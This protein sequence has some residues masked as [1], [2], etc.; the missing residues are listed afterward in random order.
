M[1]QQPQPAAVQQRVEAMVNDYLRAHGGRA[2]V[3]IVQLPNQPLAALAADETFIPA[4]NQKLLTCGAA[5]AR[6]GSTYQFTTRV[7]LLADA[8][9]LVAGDF[10]PTL[11]DADVE[12]SLGLGRYDELDR[13]AAAVKTALGGAAIKRVLIEDNPDDST[14]TPP[15]W[16]E[17]NARAAYVAPACRLNYNNNCLDVTFVLRSGQVTP[18]IFPY[19]RFYRVIDQTRPGRTAT[20]SLT[21]NA[22]DSILTLKGSV[23][24]SASTRG[25][26]SVAVKS[27]P[28]LLGRALAQRLV[29]AGLTFDPQT[30]DPVAIVPAQAPGSADLTGAKLVAVTRRPLGLAMARA[31]KDSLNMAAECLLL[32]SGDGTWEGSARIAVETL[33]KTFGLDPAKLAIRDGSGLSRGNR[34]SPAGMTTMLTALAARPDAASVLGSMSVAGADGTLGKRMTALDQRVLGKTGYIHGVCCLSG[35]VLDRSGKPQIAFAMFANGFKGRA[36][37]FKDVQDNICRLLVETLD[38]S[39]PPQPPRQ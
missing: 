8:S 21:G 9:V 26:V 39:A 20:W 15:D 31:G 19:S 1:A 33:V 12:S 28:L 25:G 4:S 29:L 38:A 35:Y 13:W 14:Y 23:V 6:L 2:G 27:P 7:Y 30:P 17:P 22:D 10:D 36:Q 32:R 34:V 16:S 11:G 24:A 3:S 18:R 37:N 5:L